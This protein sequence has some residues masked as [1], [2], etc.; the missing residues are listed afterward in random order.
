MSLELYLDYNGSTPVHPEVLDTF[1]AFVAGSYGNTAAAHYEGRRAR[2]ILDTAKA[3]I[4]LAIG[5]KPEEIWIT[6]G[7][8]ESNNWALTGIARQYGR[9]GHLIT[10]AVEHRSVLKSAEFL[11]EDGWSVSYLQVDEQGRIDPGQLDHLFQANT[12]LVSVML[13]NN[14]T[15]AIQP[16]AEVA[17][18]CRTRRIPFHVDAV[19][20]LGKMPIDVNDIPC[21]L[22]SLSAHKMYAP[23]GTG[24]LY[25]REGLP[26]QP[27]IQGCGQQAG[28]RGGTVNVEGV[29]ALAKSFALMKA[30]IYGSKEHIED[31]REQMI[32]GLR[33]LA[34]D[35][36]ING[37]APRLANTIS[38]TFP[39]RRAMDLLQALN[40]HGVSVSSG[41]AATNAA[42]SHVL[43]AMG[44]SEEQA[45]ST[46]RLTLGAFSTR[47]G[48]DRILEAFAT[49]LQKV[50]VQDPV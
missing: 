31:L 36:R 32:D 41:S 37:N 46:L 50:A 1:T 11:V 34:P 27:L 24:I 20:A 8:T 42:P 45:R 9:G 10:T 6:S 35:L 23:K 25:V 19:A 21:D 40:G 43:T 18:F 22:L 49:V 29:V 33:R 48:I 44:F 47:E 39:G 2:R 30:G 15:G 16:V 4:A 38:A 3:E 17:R 14:E 7:G 12:C 26:I 28:W 13:A 5:A